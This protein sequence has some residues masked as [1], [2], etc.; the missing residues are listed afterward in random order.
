MAVAFVAAD[1]AVAV[2]RTA[3][4]HTATSHP[5]PPTPRPVATGQPAVPDTPAP[6]QP[7]LAKAQQADAR[8]LLRTA[9]ANALA[10]GSVH[11]VAENVSQKYGR[12]VFDTYSNKTGGR[13]HLT[14]YGGNIFVR[15]VGPATY[16]TGDRSGLH[17]FFVDLTADQLA[18]I[19]HSWQELQAP[20]KGYHATTRGITIQSLLHVDRMV[21][22][23]TL[24]PVQTRDGARV[25]GIRGKAGG[26]GFG[27][28]ATATMWISAGDAPL[29]V[30]Y[31][32]TSDTLQSRQSFSDW[33]SPID[34][35]PPRK[36]H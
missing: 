25:V 16:F 4:S 3:G 15:V 36:A 17:G 28:H 24:L 8:S 22:P 9:L 1:I 12:S 35:T 13:Q 7:V 6:E 20:D 29:P 21:G 10:E 33:G 18:V 23:L 11:T 5:Q 31:V 30:E 19:Q 34:V 2:H 14:I 32:V 27:K 26:P